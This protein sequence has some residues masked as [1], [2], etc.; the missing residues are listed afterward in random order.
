MTPT[1]DLIEEMRELID[2]EIPASGTEADTAFTN[3]RLESILSQSTNLQ[4]AAA[5]CWR[6]K[7]AKIQKQI[8]ELSSYQVGTERY[9]YVN[10][11]TALNS[12]LKMAEVF[13]VQSDKQ[14]P[15]NGSFMLKI[16]PPKVL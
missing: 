11:T 14:T 10:L 1:P 5:E 15:G 13:D 3:A 8:G 16:T 7:A 4:A 12:A 6:R 9:E 2:E